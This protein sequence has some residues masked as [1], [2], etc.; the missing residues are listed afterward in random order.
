MTKK[1]QEI[2][3][4]ISPYLSAL[5]KEIPEVMD[6]FF[7]MSKAAQKEGA[8]SS[9]TKELIALCLG[10]A[11]HCDGCIAFHM[12]TLIKLGLTRR[13]L[14][15]AL[16]VAIYMGGGPSVMYGADALRAFDE[17]ENRPLA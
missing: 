8:L 6:E 11:S 13:E 17:M 16:S 15:E 2:A 1:Y 3:L 10:I 5:R 14:L 9:K 12:Q 7:T 4:D